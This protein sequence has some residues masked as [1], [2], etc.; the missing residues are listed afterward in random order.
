MGYATYTGERG[1]VIH[2]V[3]MDSG[4]P[5]SHFRMQNVDNMIYDLRTLVEPAES[6]RQIRPRR[7]NPSPSYEIERKIFWKTSEIVC[8]TDYCASVGNI[9]ARFVGSLLVSR[10]FYRSAQQRH[11]TNNPDSTGRNQG[12]SRLC[13]Y[14]FGNVIGTI[15][16][17]SLRA[18][19]CN[20]G[21]KE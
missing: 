14:F 6:G 9:E 11:V 2:F 4:C 19:L 18:G 13:F 5:P 8:F 12:K 21:R 20:E 17:I 15:R 1:E 7:V 3:H 16:R 10:A